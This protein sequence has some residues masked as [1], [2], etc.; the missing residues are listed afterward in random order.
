M[1][2]K[3]QLIV[4]ILTDATKAATGLDKAA[5]GFEAFA[6]KVK[7]K[8]AGALGGAAILGFVK[9]AVSAASDLQQAMG[10][11]D[12]VFKS[13]AAQV[14]EWASDTTD[15]IRLPQAEFEQLATI[16]GSQLKNAGVAMDDLAPKTKDLIQLGAD[17]G[18]RFGKSTSEA[19]GALSSAL[20]GEMDPLEA[21]GITLNANAVKAEEMALGLDTSTTAAEQSA[22]AQATLSLIMK[23]SADAQGAASSESDT[24]AAAQEHLTE[25]FTNL[26]AAVGGPLLDGLASFLNLVS[27]LMPV[28]QPV[29]VA[30]SSLVSGITELPAPVLAT[31]AAFA[32]YQVLS[33][34]AGGAGLVITVMTNLRVALMLAGIAAKGFFAS[35]GPIGWVILAV[36]ALATAVSIFAKDSD[37]DFAK[38]EESYGKMIDAFKQGGIAGLK[39]EIFDTS[40]AGG[41]DKALTNAGVS[42]K[43]YIDASIGAKGAS[44][45][46]AAE[47]VVA[48]NSIF[49]Q[50][51]AFASIGNDAKAAGINTQEFIGSL[52][53][54]DMTRLTAQM[55]QYADEQARLSG[56]QQTGTDIMNRWNDALGSGQAT[57]A[58]L[59]NVNALATQNQEKL[60]ASMSTAAD[61]ARALGTAEGDMAGNTLDAAA[62][63]QKLKEDTDA[64]KK[65]AES[66]GASTFLTAMK[67]E[68]D[69]ANRALEIFLTTLE[70]YTSRNEAA[71][72]GTV[73]W[74]R[75]LQDAGGAIKAMTEEGKVSSEELA[76]WGVVNLQATEASQKAYDALNN[77][78]QGYAS[79]VTQAF[80]AAGGVSNLDAA[81]QAASGAAQGAY[82]DF[83]AMATAAGL[84]DTQAQQLANQLGILNAQ[85]IDP[86]VFQLIAQDEGARLKLQQ[87]Q[88]QGIDPKTVTVSAVTDPATGAVKQMLSYI[89]AS[90][91]TVNVDAAVDPATSE[92]GKVESGSY[93]ATVKTDANTSKAV[94]D[95]NQ[96]AKA[97]YEGTIKV[98]ADTSQANR[99]VTDTMSYIN[100]LTGTIRVEASDQATGTINAIAS[101][102]YQAT[103]TVKADTSQYMSAF[104]ALPTSKTITQNVVSV[105]APAPASVG[106]MA[107]VSTL[108]RAAGPVAGPRAAGGTSTGAPVN[109]T[110]NGA[111]DPDSTARQIQTILRTRARRS[112]GIVLRGWD[113]V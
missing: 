5:G 113:Q 44:E 23:Q 7:G 82:N 34:F 96:T 28:I 61:K 72:A 83:I 53:A 89:D 17:L 110:I 29:I 76:N 75:G 57:A 33:S 85:Q 94:S 73:G 6:D 98:T 14:H 38:V 109:I 106:L 3:T 69:N 52:A 66:T 10:G 90:G 63:Q 2:N 70:T 95:I 18:A 36:G 102:Y 9:S 16:I 68:T 111:I 104:N 13:N 78:A 15:S 19:V 1:A 8:L 41:F 22:K 51:K 11:V 62:A 80:S 58:A 97:N 25:V 100:R 64:A 48:T 84:T 88:A 26:L 107:G 47:V 87:L 56:S 65:A 101:R 74:V 31:I 103:I 86:K 4:E 50:G 35:I 43:T 21:F 77:Q 105:P 42:M 39:A 55:Q 32:A 59:M 108:G 27:S 45:Q 99:F 37:D 54:G 67:N 93:D 60:S 30:I 112:M 92:I 49:D 12:A 91:A 79:V 40:A 81:T 46:L 20:K 71:E 24:F